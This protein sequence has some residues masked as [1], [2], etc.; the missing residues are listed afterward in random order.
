MKW[1]GTCTDITDRKRAEQTLKD[2]ELELRQARDL[3]EIKVMERTKELRRNEAYLAEAQKLSKTGSF[4]WNVSGGEIYWSEE[5]FR[6]FE[7]G[8][9]TKTWY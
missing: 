6:I 4:G 9:E 1:F 2:Q 8:R 7:Y 3:L 5:T